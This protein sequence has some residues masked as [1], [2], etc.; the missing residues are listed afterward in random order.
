MSGH[1][2]ADTKLVALVCSNTMQPGQTAMIRYPS[3]N[4]DIVVLFLGQK[5]PNVQ[6]LIDNGKEDGKTRRWECMPFQGMIMYDAFS[7]GK[8]NSVESSKTRRL[9]LLIYLLLSVMRWPQARN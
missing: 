5:F 3:G 8:A 6:M 9:S 2:E 4:T 1:E 7:K